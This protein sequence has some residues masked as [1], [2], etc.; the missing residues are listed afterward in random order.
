MKIKILLLIAV[1]GLGFYLLQAKAQ[2]ISSSTQIDVSLADASS[3]LATSSTTTVLSSDNASSSSV[4]S[5]S[6]ST[7]DIVA[8]SSSSNNCDLS[9]DLNKL[10]EI[11]KDSANLSKDKLNEDLQIRR[12]ILTKS[13]NCEID[14]INVL[15]SDLANLKPTSD[16]LARLKSQYLKNLN[17]IISFYNSKKSQVNKLKIA[18]TKQLSEEILKKKQDDFNIQT[19]LV[20]DFVL[21]A[22]NQDVL[23]SL[24]N[25]IQDV[26]RYL[27][28]WS[29]FD[30]DVISSNFKSSQS[31]LNMAQE[32]SSEIEDSFS[33]STIS[34]SQV[35]DLTKSFLQS[36]YNTYQDLINLQS[37][38]K[39]IL[40]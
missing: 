4:A 17:D 30:K 8:S 3:S 11:E 21:W 1:F 27:K 39:K 37:N 12:D 15:K 9:D 23:S 18:G 5:S 35:N 29:L 2:D 38:I 14:N 26:N 24:S 19:Q 13:L 6:T 10:S 32:I 28:I 40:P 16:K 20:I 31:D 36:I 33:S 22:K 34:V 25:N 7:A